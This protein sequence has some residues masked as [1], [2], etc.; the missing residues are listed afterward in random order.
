[1]EYEFNFPIQS[2]LK[3]EEYDALRKAAS[4][5]N[6][7]KGTILQ[8]GQSECHGL[9]LVRNGQL[10]AYTTNSE[11]E[12]TLYRLFEDDIC[13]FSASCIMNNLQ[14]DV[15]I[16][17][18]ENTDIWVIKADVYKKLMES[19]VIIANYTNELM[20]SRFSE[21]MWLFEQVMFHSFDKRLANFLQNE[22]SISG[23]NLL[24]MTHEEIANHLGSA[25]E[26]V[27]RMLKHFQTD[28]I[29]KLSRGSIEII[30]T[31]K[32]DDICS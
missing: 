6:I 13:L 22:I 23:S 26:V 15:Y 28:N 21:V 19:S 8:A 12:I 20:A 32:L 10:R 2:K 17:A 9:F 16:E 14:F 4:P 1:M 11:R 18:M 5:R 3:P 25:R 24:T 30:D 31:K 29:V 27:T 7:Q